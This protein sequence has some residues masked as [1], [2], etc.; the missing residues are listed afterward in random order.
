MS[1]LRLGPRESPSM[2]PSALCSR[3]A[4]DPAVDLAALLATDAEAEA[5][6]DSAGVRVAEPLLTADPARATTPAMTDGEASESP[7][8]SLARPWGVG[9]E[10]VGPVNPTEPVFLQT[11]AP[12]PPSPQASPM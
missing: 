7:G 9:L 11:E 2:D 8:D 10:L 1:R 12:G 3:G 5:E 6:A 4:A